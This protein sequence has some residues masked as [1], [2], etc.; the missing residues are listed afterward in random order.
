MLVYKLAR[1]LLAALT[2]EVTL[3]EC[4]WTAGSVILS[5]LWGRGPPWRLGER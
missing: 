1:L 5:L 2:P 3:A 4:L